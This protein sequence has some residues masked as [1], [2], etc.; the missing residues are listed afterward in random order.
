MRHDDLEDVNHGVLD[1]SIED[2]LDPA[3]KV[4]TSIHVKLRSEKP[5]GELERIEFL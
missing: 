3:Q 2:I 4:G 5:G 1:A